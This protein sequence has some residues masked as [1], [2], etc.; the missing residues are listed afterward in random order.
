MKSV[1][2]MLFMYCHKLAGGCLARPDIKILTT[3]RVHDIIVA[4]VRRTERSFC[5]M[6]IVGG[7]DEE[8]YG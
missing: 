7:T 3:M 5:R 6:P 4:T 2:R 1:R 8:L